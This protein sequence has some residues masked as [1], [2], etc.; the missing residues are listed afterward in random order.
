[1]INELKNK[2]FVLAEENIDLY[3]HICDEI[4]K[5]PEMGNEEYY[6][7]KFLVTEMEKRG[8]RVQYPYGG[9]DTAFR[10]EIGEGSPKIAFLA[11]YDAL[12]GYGPNKDQPGHACGHNWIAACTFG[13]ADVLAQLKEH[14]NGTIV[15][16]GTPA[17]EGTGGKVDLVNAGCFDDIDAAFQMHLTGSEKTELNG[18]SLAIDSLEFTFEGKAA[19]AAGAPWD[20]I[21][22]LDAAYLMINGINALRQHVKPDTRIHGIIAEG[23]MAPNIV[24]NHAV[25]KVFCRAAD[26]DYLNTVTQKVINCAKGAELMT[27]ATMSYRYYENS[28]DNLNCNPVLVEVMANNLTAMGYTNFNKEKKEPSGSTDLGN[29]SRVVP[30]CY[31]S[32]NVE[33]TDG[34]TCHNEAFLAHVNGELAYKANLTAIKAMAASAIDVLMNEEIRNAIAK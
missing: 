27:G 11:E 18:S 4:F 12:P 21:N 1:M 30:T 16:I 33:N 17:E 10:C 26:R 8:F 28:F 19:H 9:L 32:L 5:H 34:S 20:G 13:A 29:V 22:A 2:A 15:Y 23:G 3:N 6:S 14:F 7:S 25:Y 31:V 24:P